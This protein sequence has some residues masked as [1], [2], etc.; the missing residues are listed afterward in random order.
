MDQNRSV[1][2]SSRIR[3]LTTATCNM[4]T[5]HFFIILNW[6]I[7]F[8]IISMR[9]IELNF[10][11][12]IFWSFYQS[13]YENRWSTLNIIFSMRRQFQKWPKTFW[14]RWLYQFDFSSS[15]SESKFLIRKGD[16]SKSPLCLHL[17]LVFKLKYHCFDEKTF[18]IGNFDVYI[19][20]SLTIRVLP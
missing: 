17:N 19:K 4:R 8:V 5:G 10:E 13:F 11:K 2:G 6:N 1:R 14:P 20:L 9:G 16:I 12:L 7:N 3:K 18:S 15:H